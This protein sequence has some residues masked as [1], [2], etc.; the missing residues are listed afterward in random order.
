MRLRSFPLLTTIP[1][2]SIVALQKLRIE[3]GESMTVDQ[4][5]TCSRHAG[6]LYLVVVLAG[7]AG[8]MY[9][10]SQITVSGD[11]S[12]TI[13]N[14]REMEFLYRLGAA[15]FIVQ[16]ASFVFLP[17][18][19]YRLL[20]SVNETAAVLMVI[21]ALVSVPMALMS[22]AHKLDALS[23]LTDPRFAGIPTEL[24]HIQMNMALESYSNGIALTSLFWGLWLLPFGYLVYASRFLPKTLGI[25]LMIG[26]FGYV[27]NFFGDLL[28]TGYAASGLE[29]L[30]T[31]PS[32]LG[33]IGICLWMLT[34]GARPRA[35]M[36]APAAA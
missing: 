12:A 19:L 15:A 24:L 17:L 25:L 18:V 32:G 2:S 20:R 36:A 33:E 16:I 9:V 29:S 5:R 11:I 10:P 6:A 13:N 27:I 34:V 35:M 1:G 14:M 8:M 28:W 23:L 21:L 31:L 3:K 30:V 4:M 22:L 7:I 26:C